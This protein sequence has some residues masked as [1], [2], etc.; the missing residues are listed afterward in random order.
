M[1]NK[2]LVLAHR[3]A[4]LNAPENTMKAFIRAF[5]NGADGIECDIRVT[6][7]GEFIAFHDATTERLVGVNWHI[8]KT[9]YA[10]LRHLEVSG[11]EPIA[12]LD[13]ILKLLIKKEGKLC[14]FEI[15]FDNIDDVD[16]LVKKIKEAG[17]TKRSYI[18]AFSNKKHILKRA[19]EIS[20]EIGI[21]IMP[22]LPTKIIHTAQKAKA[23]SVCLGW[24]DWPGAKSLFSVFTKFSDL[25]KQIQKARKLNIF[26]SGGV[27]N[28]PEE[29]EWFCE[30]GAQGV[31]TDDVLMALEVI[32]RG[33]HV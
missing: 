31:W 15:C 32:E 27:A 10:Q 29:I 19:K 26:V 14:F 25:K 13:D 3:G 7:D 12:H 21:S 30:Q 11:Q 28:T 5:E 18:L 4:L 20:P 9:K 2:P 22:L 8:V 33:K 1:A 24:V 16:R 17:L 6:A 23:N